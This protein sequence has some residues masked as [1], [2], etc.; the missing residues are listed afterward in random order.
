MARNVNKEHNDSLSLNDRLA[1]HATTIIGTMWCFYLFCVLAF[2]GLP[3]ALATGSAAVLVNWLSSNFLQLV[4]LPLLL[5]SQ[6]VQ[7]RHDQLR[8][9]ADYELDQKE[10]E[11]LERILEILEGK[12]D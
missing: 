5:V 7:S 3:A 10:E 11:Q 6:N 12:N 9:D 4:L 1:L 8:A 2:Y